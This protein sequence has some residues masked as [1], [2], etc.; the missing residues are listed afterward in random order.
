[1]QVLAAQFPVGIPRL[2]VIRVAAQFLALVVAMC[3]QD[4]G[5]T[6]SQSVPSK[7]GT[8]EVCDLRLTVQT[9]LDAVMYVDFASEGVRILIDGTED[10]VGFAILLN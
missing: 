10:Q 4:D 8:F 2:V 7:Y 5:V 1:M 9:K 3:T 6:S